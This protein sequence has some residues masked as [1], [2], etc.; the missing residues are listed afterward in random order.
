MTLNAKFGGCLLALFLGAGLTASSFAQRSDPSNRPPQPSAPAPAPAPHSA[1]ATV[2]HSTPPP[3]ARQ[4]SPPPR[5]SQA[6][7]RA[8]VPRQY[9][10]TTG[11]RFAPGMQIQIPMR[12]IQ[13][14]RR[15]ILIGP[16][17]TIKHRT[18][19]AR[20]LV[21]ISKG[22]NT[23]ATGNILRWARQLQRLQK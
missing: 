4:G 5:Q 14:I 1:P 8:A 2:P 18:L 10:A 23:L 7:H 19:I 20:R 6:A 12:G 15:W 11:L 13:F 16:R 17:S 21:N 3:A 9:L 22:G